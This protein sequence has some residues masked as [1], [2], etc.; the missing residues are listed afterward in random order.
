MKQYKIIGIGEILWDLLPGGKQLGGAPG[1][2]A[3]HCQQ[4]GAQ[5]Y[6]LSAVGKDG[7]GDEIQQ[8]LNAQHLGR[9][10]TVLPA[11]PTGTVEVELSSN[12]IPQYTIHEDVA[13]DYIPFSPEI[14][15]LA[16]AAHAI[17][18]GSLAQR[19]AVSAST[20]RRLLKSAPE[21]CLKVFDINL[22]QHFYS[23]VIIEDSLRLC[24]VLKINKEELMVLQEFYHLPSEE[25]A[26]L[27]S[28]I[29]QY[30]LKWIALT[31]G[32][33]GSILMDARGEVSE[34]SSPKV[35]VSDTVGAGDAFTAALVMGI[36]K[37]QPLKDL[38]AQAV[39]IAAFVCTQKGAMPALKAI[40]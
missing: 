31:K 11:Q 26:A 20:I 3:F 8:Q 40:L 23:K 10:I 33:E 28:L 38:H 12:G 1:N 13:W 6:L 24:N 36:L 35:V 34:L 17:C 16:E 22:R 18:F 2:F 9:Y 37:G 39:K 29:G 15:V 27:K 14:Q 30:Q 32:A 4:L 19:S 25:I 5:S 7:L 21:D